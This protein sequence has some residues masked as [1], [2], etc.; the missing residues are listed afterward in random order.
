MNREASLWVLALAVAAP[1]MAYAGLA[2]RM[3][4]D[5]QRRRMHRRTISEDCQ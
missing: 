5:G 1:N 3:W 2:W 4:R